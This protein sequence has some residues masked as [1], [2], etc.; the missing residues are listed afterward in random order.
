MGLNVDMDVLK[1]RFGADKVMLLSA[2]TLHGVDSFTK[3]LKNY[4][5]GGEG[6][7]GDGAYVQNARQERLL[8]Q[9]LQ[10][11]E[12]CRQSL[13]KICCLMIASSLM[14]GPLLIY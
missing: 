12:G 14:L 6:T 2:K 3:W 13:Q 9:A 8:R 10:S 5:Y 1:Q 4:V 7:L 11:L